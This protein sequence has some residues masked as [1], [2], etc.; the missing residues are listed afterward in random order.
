MDESVNSADMTETEKVN[1]G[2]SALEEHGADVPETEIVSTDKPVLEERGAVMF[3]TEINDAGGTENLSRAIL[4]TFGIAPKDV[5]T[6]SPLV[7]AFIGDDVF[8]LIIRTIIVEEANAPVNV[9]HKKASAIVKAA[10][11]K[12]IYKAIA[13]E[14]TD[15]EQSVYRR[16]RNAKSNTMAK[17]ASVGEYRSATGFE[18]LLGFLYLSGQ[19][20]RILTLVRLGLQRT[21]CLPVIK[22]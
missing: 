20:E 21:G 15:V 5:H 17:N 9:L 11:Q 1:T 14:L 13:D 22:E 12:E 3:D 16:G 6:Y 8:D 18:A 4:D 7:L 10:S 19:T 2:K